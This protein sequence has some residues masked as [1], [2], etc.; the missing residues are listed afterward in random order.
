[1]RSLGVPEFIAAVRSGATVWDTRPPGSS[2]VDEVPGAV[3]VSLERARLG[4]IPD[5]E[6]DSEVILV[7]EWGRLSELA[8]LY[9]EAHGVTQ[10]AHLRGGLAALRRAAAKAAKPGTESH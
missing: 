9:L 6:P 4:Q 10:V 1:M 7:C 2:V 5:V 3:R 8:G